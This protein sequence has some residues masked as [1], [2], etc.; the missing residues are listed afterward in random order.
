MFSVECTVCVSTG[1]QDVFIWA[2]QIPHF[3]EE[4]A[5]HLPD[6]MMLAGI[7]SELTVG[8]YFFDMSVSV[9][10]IRNCCPIG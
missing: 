3:F 5:Q 6:V 2:K 10:V 4:V 7:T 9:K 8:S 1:S